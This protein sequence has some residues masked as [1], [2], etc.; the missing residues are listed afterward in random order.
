MSSVAI[1]KRQTQARL[2]NVEDKTVYNPS[3][4]M[5]I[6]GLSWNYVKWNSQW[7]GI[8]HFN[9]EENIKERWILKYVY[10]EVTLVYY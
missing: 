7:K 10:S 2:R 9:K 1:Q 4:S 8:N 3:N 5:N 6:P